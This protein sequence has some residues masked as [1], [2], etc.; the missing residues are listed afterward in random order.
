L[1]RY[2][3]LVGEGQKAKLDKNDI[4]AFNKFI[5]KMSIDERK[6]LE[7]QRQEV[8]NLVKGQ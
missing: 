3:S 6:A 1:M 5:G 2:I 7:Q 4:E 8:L